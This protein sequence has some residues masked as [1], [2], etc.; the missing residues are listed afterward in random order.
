MQKSFSKEWW[1][2]NYGF[3][4]EFYKTGDNSIE[5]SYY[6]RKVNREQRTKEEVNG[7]INLCNLKEEDK[8]LDCPCGWGRHSIALSKKKMVVTGSDLN[9][10]ELSIAKKEAKKQKVN[11]K[12]IQEDM[13]KLKYKNKFNAVIN[14]W[15]S[16]GFFDI[17]KDNIKTLKNFYE[18]LKKGGKFLMHTH[19]NVPWIL[20]GNSKEYEKRKLKGGGFLR[21]IEF[22]EA[23]SKRNHGIWILEKDGIVESRDYSV[24]IY[25]KN[26]FT[27]I[28]KKAGFKKVEI[29]SDWEG[30]K[31][32]PKSRTMVVVATK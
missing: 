17:E 9:S 21:Q 15:Y 14:L 7:V 26:E 5:G 10:F 24:R 12:F 31:Y 29:Y 27:K 22:Y 32:S 18:A 8:V 2:E 16:F 11:A 1:M 30:T 3:F 13:R 6:N 20:A 19:K 4:G 23:K 28:C 25:S